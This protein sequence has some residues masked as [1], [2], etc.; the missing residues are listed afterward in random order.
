MLKFSLRLLEQPVTYEA[1]YYSLKL[2]Q[3]TKGKKDQVG[4]N[5]RTPNVNTVTHNTVCSQIWE[6][7]RNYIF[8]WY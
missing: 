4:V 6:D 7:W 2:I 3:R 1:I 5:L 8:M